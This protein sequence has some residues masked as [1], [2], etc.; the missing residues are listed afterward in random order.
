ME[1]RR[2]TGGPRRRGRGRPEAERGSPVPP[3]PQSPADP[4][5]FGNQKDY[6]GN[7]RD[8]YATQ[9]VGGRG[10]VGTT[11]RGEPPGRGDRPARGGH[12]GRGGPPFRGGRPVRDARSESPAEREAAEREFLAEMEERLQQFIESDEKDLALEPMNS[13][14][15]RLVH[16][17]AKTF[18]IQTESRGEDR[19]RYVYLIRTADSIV[20][21]ESSVA[22]VLADSHA[23]ESVVSGSAPRP[24]R[25]SR[26]PAGRERAGEGRPHREPVGREQGGREQ[27]G[28]EQGGRDTEIVDTESPA[29]ESPEAAGPPARSSHR[30]AGRPGPREGGRE[31][32]R[33]RGRRDS[34][35][36]GGGG[37]AVDYGSQT[38]PVQPGEQGVHIA[39]KRDGS[40]EIF[41]EEDRNQVL[42][43]R[44]VTSRL[45]RV[46]GGKIVQPGEPGW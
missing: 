16:N 35:G 8:F 17:L 26:A 7:P 22:A 37:R 43:E 24:E 3:R 44:L 21:E 12:P 40:I 32:F 11:S 13:F 39:L 1:G 2:P 33:D 19:D 34:Y 29:S 31:G 18:R 28:R 42:T 9:E 15:R 20:P 5:N 23:A 14:K 46:R 10:P 41:R 30:D 36:E 6:Y 45:I 4:E 25:A 38:F 27:G